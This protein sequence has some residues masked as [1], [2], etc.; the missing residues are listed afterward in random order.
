MTDSSSKTIGPSQA[1]SSTNALLSTS[2]I[3]DRFGICFDIS[4]SMSSKYLNIS[5]SELFWDLWLFCLYWGWS[6]T[7]DF[8]VLPWGGSSPS[9]PPEHP[10]LLCPTTLI[11]LWEA[12]LLE[13]LWQESW[14]VWEA[15]QEG[16]SPSGIYWVLGLLCFN[17]FTFVL[18]IVSGLLS[19]STYC[20]I[21]FS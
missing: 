1:K 3:S 9:P 15:S 10:S 17:F 11:F 7:W 6:I 16:D 20:G 4:T 14:F 8:S 13:E 18:I 21:K 2:H 19:L 12:L 5:N